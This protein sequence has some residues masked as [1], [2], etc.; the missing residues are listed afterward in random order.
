[1]NPNLNGFGV[2]Y[3]SNEV[4]IPEGTT[5]YIV[6]LPDRP[7]PMVSAINGEWKGGT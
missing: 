6:E 5:S 4:T 7:L 1:M 2:S 3:Y